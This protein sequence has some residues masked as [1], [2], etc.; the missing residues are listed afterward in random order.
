MKPYCGY[1]ESEGHTFSSC[2]ERDDESLWDELEDDFG[3]VE[4]G[5]GNI[6]S[7]ADPGL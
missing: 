6:L 1:C 3:G 4:D 2:P 7:D 5:F